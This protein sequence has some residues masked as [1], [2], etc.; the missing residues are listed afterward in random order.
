MPTIFSFT[1]ESLS[2]LRKKYSLGNLHQ[3]EFCG[4]AEKGTIPFFVS[5]VMTTSAIITSIDML[6]SRKTDL[7]S[8]A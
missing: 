6:F 7:Q 4:W 8:I 3:S 5:V 1:Y 2:V